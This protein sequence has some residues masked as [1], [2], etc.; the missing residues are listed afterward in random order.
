[1]KKKKIHLA[2]YIILW[3]LV[4]TT[5]VLL[6]GADYFLSPLQPGYHE[7]VLAGKFSTLVT[8]FWSAYMVIKRYFIN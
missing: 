1:M 8:L 7:M 3:I 6:L 4:L 5:A 2:E